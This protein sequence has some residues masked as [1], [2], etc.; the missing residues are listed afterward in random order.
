MKNR[1]ERLIKK[2]IRARYIQR[3]KVRPVLAA[4]EQLKILMA[5][6][7]AEGVKHGLK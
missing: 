7:V 6:P 2:Q 5:V 3:N 1:S 4:V